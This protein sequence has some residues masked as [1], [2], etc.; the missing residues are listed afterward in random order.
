MSEDEIRDI[1]RE[2]KKAL[3]INNEQV[4]ISYE[5]MFIQGL[6]YGI[7]LYTNSIN[8]I[9]KLIVQRLCQ[10]N[11]LN[12][13]IADKELSQGVNL[14]FRLSALVGY[15]GFRDFDPIFVQQASGR[16]GR[17]GKDKKGYQCFVNVD[18]SHI[19]KG[20]LTDLNGHIDNETLSVYPLLKYLNPNIDYTKIYSKM[21][22][23]T[24]YN[25]GYSL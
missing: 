6:K 5:N 18:W 8:D 21:P 24:T 13:V 4:N 23:K 25:L 10:N 14:P 1:R 11:K 2:I 19:M 3:I 20:K 22:R 12:I 17:R 7:G 9:Y 15:N 16:S